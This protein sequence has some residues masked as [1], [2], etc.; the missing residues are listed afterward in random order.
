[1]IGADNADAKKQAPSYASTRDAYAGPDRRLA[2]GNP[3]QQLWVK[4]REGRRTPRR[5][6][7][8]K[9]ARRRRSSGKKEC[10][11]HHFSTLPFTTSR[12]AAPRST[13]RF[14]HGARTSVRSNRR[15]L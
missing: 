10:E 15:R 2:A 14:W 8:F 11:A 1:M 9:S 6:A 3:P 13:R 4:D 12:W 7:R 5:F